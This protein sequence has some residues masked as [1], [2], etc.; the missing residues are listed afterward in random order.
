MHVPVGYASCRLHYV[1]VDNP[2]K[3]ATITYGVQN[4]ASH[5]PA[6]LAS[7]LWSAAVAAGSIASTTLMGVE[8]SLRQSGITLMT[9]TGPVTADYDSIN[10]GAAE[11]TCPPI[12]CCVLVSKNTELGG[13]KGHGRMFSPPHMVDELNVTVEGELGGAQVAAYQDAFGTW[14]TYIT[15]TL[16]LPFVLFHA[17]LVTDP[18]VITSL[19]VES[20]IS[21]QRRRLRR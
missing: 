3:G 19:T 15:D 16:N 6:W 21:T 8:W 5:T 17:D 20:T 12:N 7:N 9:G 4:L 2:L 1:L 11:I 13:R 10:N 18:T 14:M